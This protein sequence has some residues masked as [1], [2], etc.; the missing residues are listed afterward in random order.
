MK[1]RDGRL[2]YH[3]TKLSNLDSIIENG[4]VSRKIL[5]DKAVT[6]ADIADNDIMDKRK[7]FGLD[8][9]IPFH[10]HPY[11]S[12]DKAVI[13]KYNEEFIYICITRELARNK[14]FFILPKHPLSIEEVEILDYDE[15][16]NSIDWEAM[17]KSSTESSYI[18]QVK[19]AECL[20]ELVVP[21][22][23][24]TQ[25]AVRNEEIKEEVEEKLKIFGQAKPHVNIQPWLNKSEW[26]WECD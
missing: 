4:L 1:I 9:Y 26:R 6:F 24:F 14:N 23:C 10:F 25:I 5:E 21:V 22:E 11:S 8:K 17:E 7:K 18:K 16:I 12:F 13:N 20:T 3:L 2:L 15:G 19:M